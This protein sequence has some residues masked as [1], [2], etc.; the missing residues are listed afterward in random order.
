MNIAQSLFLMLFQSA[1]DATE[2][3]DG[4]KDADGEDESR[5]RVKEYRPKVYGAI[6]GIFNLYSST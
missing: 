4:L 1:P 5:S 2:I 3:L 6:P